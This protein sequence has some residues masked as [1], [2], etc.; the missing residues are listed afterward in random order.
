M[1]TSI[2]VFKNQN[3]TFSFHE[4]KTVSSFESV[5]CFEFSYIVHHI[6]YIHVKLLFNW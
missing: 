4:K 1:G 2:I 6:Q 3:V 5:S